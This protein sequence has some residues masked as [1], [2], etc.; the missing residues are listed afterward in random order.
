MYF[1]AHY[2]CLVFPLTL[3]V[4]ADSIA[5]ESYSNSVK[6]RLFQK[7]FLKIYR[8]SNSCYSLWLE[9]GIILY[10]PITENYYGKIQS[11]I[12]FRNL[13]RRREI[14]LPNFSEI[15]T[16]FKVWKTVFPYLPLE[17]SENFDVQMFW[18]SFRNLAWLRKKSWKL[19]PI[20]RALD[21]IW[22]GYEFKTVSSETGRREWEPVYFY[23]L[24]DLWSLT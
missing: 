15:I 3:T 9:N 14:I 7:L 11:R 17:I 10:F 22:R 21:E 23:R 6:F 2:R 13:F 19:F 4:V 16:V 8:N 20:H 5:D 12:C 18:K 24:S 1:N